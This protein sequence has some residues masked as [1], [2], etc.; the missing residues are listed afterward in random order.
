MEFLSLLSSPDFT[1]TEIIP[2][3]QIHQANFPFNSS[4]DF[5]TSKPL[6]DLLPETF[7][8]NQETETN[9]TNNERQENADQVMISDLRSN[10]PRGIFRRRRFGFTTTGEESFSIESTS[11]SSSSSEDDSEESFSF[12][13]ER[14]PAL[15]LTNEI[16]RENEQP[17]KKVTHIKQRT[18]LR[19]NQNKDLLA[20]PETS[21]EIYSVRGFSVAKYN[22]L[23]KETK[24]VIST[25]FPLTAFAVSNG[26][27]FS[28]GGSS[29]LLAKNLHTNTLFFDST[30]SNSPIKSIH[31]SAQNHNE[32]STFITTSE[33]N[34]YHYKVTP[35]DLVS[36][37][38]IQTNF[39]SEQCAI[40]PNS[41]FLTVVGNSSEINIYDPNQNFAKIHTVSGMK[42]PSFSVSWSE[43]SLHFAVGSKEGICCIWDIRKPSEILS[44]IKSEQYLNMSK[45]PVRNVKFSPIYDLLLFSEASGFFSVVDSR[46]FGSRELV[47]LNPILGR[48]S[49]KKKF[50][51]GGCWSP[52]GGS[53]F[54]STPLEILKFY[55][56]VLSRRLF[57]YA[58]L[59]MN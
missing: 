34:V 29:E 27:L 25:S 39:Q 41:K 36:M 45:G 56:D 11:E 38:I 5:N 57:P 32:I 8:L 58:D 42:P 26:I 48:V 33:R 22:I 30:V 55:V 6:T 15:T 18:V 59:N 35:S 20:C 37:P 44:K 24:E 43:N 10:R 13:G 17:K 2:Q 21:E 31:V 23:T 49:F 47:S 1:N 16:N 9:T 4:I 7:L 3:I 28:G 50:L 52:D 54:I 14:N 53:L 46:T 40:S 19:P 12:F 51:I